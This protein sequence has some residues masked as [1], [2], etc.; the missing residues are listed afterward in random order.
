MDS[1]SVS[2]AAGGAQR[3]G[4]PPGTR[5]DESAGAVQVDFNPRENADTPQDRIAAAISSARPARP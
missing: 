4:T 2:A 5:E 3:P 1:I